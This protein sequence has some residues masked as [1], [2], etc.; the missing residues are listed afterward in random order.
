MDKIIVELFK[1]KNKNYKHIKTIVRNIPSKRMP[2]AN[3]PSNKK[4]D[5]V[6]TM[7]HEYIVI[8]QKY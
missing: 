4:G 1:I 6:T 7:N 8:I 2:K 5:K 3:S